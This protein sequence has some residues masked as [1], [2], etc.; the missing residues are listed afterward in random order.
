MS[1][2]AKASE[3]FPPEETT[4]NVDDVNCQ[5][6]TQNLSRQ[7]NAATMPH[8]YVY[9]YLSLFVSVCLNL[10]LSVSACLC[11]SMFVSVYLCLSLFVTVC[12]CL[13]LLFCLSVCVCMTHTVTSCLQQDLV[14]LCQPSLVRWNCI[15]TVQH[16]QC[17]ARSLLLPGHWSPFINKLNDR[18]ALPLPD[19]VGI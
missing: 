7:R 17:A 12:L 4:H 2:A 5:R 11:L 8:P 9:L 3:S 16:Y 15:S 19:V 1:N 14:F 10:S 18:P 6:N 13:S